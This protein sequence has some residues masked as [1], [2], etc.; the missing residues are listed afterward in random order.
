MGK[1]RSF[2][3]WALSILSGL[4]FLWTNPPDR[5]TKIIRFF[6]TS[7]DST[8]GAWQFDYPLWILDDPDTIWTS[9]PGAPDSA[10]VRL[11]C[12]SRPVS[13]AASCVAIDTAGNVSPP[14]NVIR[15]TN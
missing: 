7:Q 15:F 4:L 6:V 9:R 11:P 2:R 5:D 12:R 10:L 14:S 13:Y 1:P 3:W 8:G